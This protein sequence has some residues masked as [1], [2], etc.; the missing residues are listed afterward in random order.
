MNELHF[1]VLGPEGACCHGGVGRWLTDQSWLPVVHGNLAPCV[2]GYH[3]CRTSNLV[4]WLGECIWIAEGRG[5]P[6]VSNDYLIFREARVLRLLTTWTPAKARLFAVECAER[7]LPM[8]TTLHPDETRPG[9]SIQTARDSVTH[10]IPFS[11]MTEV[12]MEAWNASRRMDGAARDVAL[13]AYGAAIWQSGGIAAWAASGSAR[14]AVAAAASEQVMIDAQKTGAH[15]RDAER[16]AI[17]AASA[18]LKAEQEW[19]TKRLF[20]LL[21]D[22]TQ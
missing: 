11:R 17:A 1:K 14:T 6:F 13:A 8:I 16:S 12:A 7:V 4:E 3:L 21:G 9:L 22:V 2:R 5:K 19:Q 15:P 20:E 10:S 18:A